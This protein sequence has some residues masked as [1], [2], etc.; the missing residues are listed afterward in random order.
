MPVD[1]SRRT[2]SA[3]W[4]W[5]GTWRPRTLKEYADDLRIFF[6]YFKPHL[7]ADLTLETI[8]ERSLRDFLRHLK[9][10]RRYS[11]KALNR[12]IACLK[13][14]FKFLEKEGFVQK[15]PATDL[16]S[17]KLPKH[18]PKVLSQDDVV[19]LLE[20]RKPEED[21]GRRSRKRDPAALTFAQARDTAILELFYATGMRISEL[22]GLDL[23]DNRLDREPHPRDGQG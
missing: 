3:T 1:G 2:S 10:E 17:V 18:L 16:H 11:A 20:P 7:E 23:H 15:S 4:P 21:G 19:K 14:Y 12:K 9:V 5:S 6:E 13:N 8:D 22:V